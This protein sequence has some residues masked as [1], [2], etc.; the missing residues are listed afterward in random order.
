MLLSSVRFFFCAQLKEKRARPRRGIAV[1]S[2]SLNIVNFVELKVMEDTTRQN[3]SSR[4]ISFFFL[5]SRR[6]ILE[7]HGSRLLM[8][9]RFTRKK[10]TPLRIS[11]KKSSAIHESRNYHLPPSMN[12]VP[13]YRGGS[14]FTEY[15]QPKG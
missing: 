7:N 11:R 3:H 9:S 10:K 14:S 5:I 4:R 6:I 12:A 8:K 2:W 13:Q 1:L 15:R